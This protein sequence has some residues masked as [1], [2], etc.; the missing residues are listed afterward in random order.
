MATRLS[1]LVANQLNNPQDNR[2]SGH[3]VCQQS[4]RPVNPQ[5][6]HLTNQRNSLVGYHLQSRQDSPQATQVEYLQKDHLVALLDNHLVSLQRNQVLYL[7]NNLLVSLVGCLLDNHRDNPQ[8]VPQDIQLLNLL[9]FLLLH[10]HMLPNLLQC[11]ILQ[12]R[13]LI[14]VQNYLLDG[15]VLLLMFLIRASAH[16]NM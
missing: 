7:L 10:H 4:N 15:N 11:V 14:L 9:W 12:M 2:R 1:S 3:L 13:Y 6:F 8:V 5:K 16:G